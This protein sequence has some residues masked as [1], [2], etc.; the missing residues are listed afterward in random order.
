VLRE[1][2]AG[3]DGRLAL[4]IEIVYGHALRPLARPRVA[5]ESAFSLQDMRQLLRGE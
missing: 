3:E 4:G 5:A 2:L 1:R